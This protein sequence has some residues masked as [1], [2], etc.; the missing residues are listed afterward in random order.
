MPVVAQA[1]VAALQ[2]DT[3]TAAAPEAEAQDKPDSI[4]RPVQLA[5]AAADQPRPDIA[6]LQ[7]R[8]GGLLIGSIA[9]EGTEELGAD[10]FA[11]VVEANV[12]EVMQ[13][14]DL[15]RV[16]QEVSTIARDQGYVFATA[17][18]P[19]QAVEHGILTIEINE[20]R[21]DE[22]RVKGSDNP[23]LQRFLAPL[24]G[25]IARSDV[26]ERR[27]LLAGDLPEIRMGRTRFLKEKGKNIL[28]VRVREREDRVR[29]SVDNYGSQRIGPTRAR[30]SYDFSG[31]FDGSDRGSA[32]VRSN[33]LDPDEFAF[34]SAS[35]SIGFG[36]DGTRVGIAG[37]IGTNQPGGGFVNVEGDT[38]FVEVFASRPISRSRDASLWVDARIAY[39][40][41]EQDDVIGL[42]RQD[43]Q[44]TFSIGLS[45][46]VKLF[47]GRLRA[48]TS[49]IQGLDL[50]NATRMGSRFASRFDG[51]AVFT[52]G[53]YYANW[54]GRLGGNWGALLGVEGQIANRPLLAAQEFNIGGPF[55]VRGFDFAELAGDN[56]LAAIA[57]INYTFR[58]PNSWISW[59][60]PYAFVD[61]GYVDNLR[62]TRGGGSLISSGIG[63]RGDA[64]PINFELEGAVPLNRDRDQSEDRSPHLNLRVGIDL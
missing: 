54:R 57:E 45:S 3:S 4:V 55:S 46:N 22:V 37:S 8:D 2:A 25:T 13:D 35:Y 52:A 15:R 20:G 28:E 19:E 60:Q 63:I 50:F 48:G 27:I 23:A 61:G 30:L 14:D 36:A 17:R 44:V 42:L 24:E 49:L 26:I 1:E 7:S 34:A 6:D 58:K 38:E 21:I 11:S 33:P 31:F 29:A 59:L 51:D 18:L 41:V 12:G 47:S 32:S 39:L 64:G 9:I 62:R 43:N 56:G 5:L 10:V 16:I 53:N 40:S